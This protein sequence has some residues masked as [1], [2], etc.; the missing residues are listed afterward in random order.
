MS[1][2]QIG[3]KISARWPAHIGLVEEGG[4]IF[5]QFGHELTVLEI[6]AIRD[7]VVEVFPSPRDLFSSRAFAISAK[8]SCRGT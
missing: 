1:L 2:F 5:L 6:A 7:Y 4:K 3:Q 8:P